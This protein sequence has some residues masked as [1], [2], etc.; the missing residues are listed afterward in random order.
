MSEQSLTITYANKTAV[1]DPYWLRMELFKEEDPTMTVG[2]AADVIDALYNT[3]PCENGT[4]STKTP[5][6]GPDGADWDR[7]FDKVN[8]AEC[9]KFENTEDLGTYDV[10][11]KVYRSHQGE[12]YKLVM[13]N[14][15]A[16]LLGSRGED[17]FQ[18]L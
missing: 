8:F 18:I 9:E 6:E 5:V 11:I 3:D 13:F 17:T 12:L 15:T 16:G 2:E 14:G 1:V 7:A 10:K 4:V